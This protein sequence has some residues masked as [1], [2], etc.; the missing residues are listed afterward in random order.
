VV[1]WNVCNIATFIGEQT[2]VLEYLLIRRW[3]LCIAKVGSCYATWLNMNSVG[4]WIEVFFMNT[5]LGV[6][7]CKLNSYL[8]L[9]QSLKCGGK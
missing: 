8:S 4:Q 7:F 5:S 6:I 2:N 3:Y 9:I 1:V